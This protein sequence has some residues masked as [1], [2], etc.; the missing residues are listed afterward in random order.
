MKGLIAFDFD[1]TLY[2]ISPYDSEQRLILEANRGKEKEAEAQ[3][4]VLD[5]MAGCYDH[6]AFTRMYARLIRGAD[7]ESLDRV[8]LH[9]VS[10]VDKSD[11]TLFHKLSE[12]ADLV[13]IS[14]GT[15]EL[16]RRFLDR[17]GILSCFSAI[18]GKSL[19]WKDGKVDHLRCN[20]DAADDK[21]RVLRK[22]GSGHAPLVAVGDGPTDLPMLRAA[23]H[24]FQ[25]SL[26]GKGIT[27]PFPVFTS[28]PSVLEKIA[29]LI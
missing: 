9:L 26:A 18:C 16:C 1:G 19:V 11:Y 17:M 8:V 10:L 2:P 3:T 23:D 28:I 12:L 29:T 7:S 22:L 25:V 13:I 27:S 15:E 6:D 4:A 14:C 21:V 24:A 20:V 5:D